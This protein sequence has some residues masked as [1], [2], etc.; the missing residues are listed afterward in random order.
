VKWDLIGPDAALVEQIAKGPQRIW[1][2]FSKLALQ[3]TI[4]KAGVTATASGIDNSRAHSAVEAWA[5][6][7]KNGLDEALAFTAKWLGIADTTT[8]N[9]ST[10]F[11]VLTSSPAEITALASAQQRGV[12]SKQTERSE[13]KRRSILSPDWS[14]EQE[15]ERL[16]AEEQGAC[17]RSFRS[18]REPAR[19]STRALLVTMSSPSNR[20]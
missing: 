1:D 17:S 19:R 12:I 3:P 4:P 7:L 8:A 16:A 15:T 11:A 9:V 2:D 20:G 14:E 13:L 18:I 10:D 5:L 6:A